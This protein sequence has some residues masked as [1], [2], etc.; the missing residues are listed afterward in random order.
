VRRAV[1]S[2]VLPLDL[3]GAFHGGE[4]VQQPLG[5]VAGRQL[6]HEHDLPARIGSWRSSPRIATPLRRA[7][8]AIS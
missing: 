5:A 6:G 1:T 7:T 4:G 2:S 3:L 8:S